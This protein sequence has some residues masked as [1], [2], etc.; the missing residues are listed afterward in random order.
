MTDVDTVAPAVAESSAD[1]ASLTD[2][3]AGAGAAE[4]LASRLTRAAAAA[5]AAP[6]TRRDP[7]PPPF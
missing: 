4:S 3:P 5:D 7:G 1:A 6:W 2:S